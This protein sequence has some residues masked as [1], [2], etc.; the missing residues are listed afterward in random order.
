MVKKKRFS[1][2]DYINLLIAIACGASCVKAAECFSDIG[3]AI[4]HD[5][6]NRFLTKQVLD[7]DSLWNE[8]EQFI[9][10]RNGWLILD[11]T[12]IDKIYSKHIEMTRFQWSGKYHKVVNGIGLVTLVWTDGTHSFPVDY[13]IYDKNGDGL[14]KNEH[15][16]A[17]LQTAFT[18]NFQPYFVLFD[19]WYSSNDNLTFIDT[20]GWYWCTRVKQ[21]RMVN[22]DRVENQPVSSVFL[23]DDGRVVHMKK[24]GLVRLGHSTNKNGEDRYWITNYLKMDDVDRRNLQ[25]ICWAIEN[26]HRALKGLCCVRDCKIRKAAGQRNHINCSIRAFVRFEVA[27]L[28]EK[29]TLY[30]AKWQISKPAI[31]EYLKHPI[32]AL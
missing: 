32:Y 23:P 27:K 28:R 20:F 9:E 11:D 13:R 7:P 5:L 24:Y 2:E 25:A 31:I 22:P 30:D 16:R 19:S 6:I 1:C 17:M 10:K 8:V 15:F 18:R 12:V 21:N 29:I 3:R 4:S 26:Y 14:T